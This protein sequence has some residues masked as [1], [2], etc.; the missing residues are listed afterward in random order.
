M[1]KRDLEFIIERLYK[2]EDAYKGITTRVRLLE[3]EI[4]KIKEQERKRL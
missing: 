1:T 3:A 2:L 4:D